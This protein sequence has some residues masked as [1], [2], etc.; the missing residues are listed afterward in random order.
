MN[1]EQIESNVKSYCRQYPC[2]FNTASGAVL[3]DENDRNYI[4]F[5]SGAGTL[6][7]GH[8]NAYLK[9]SLIEYI[10]NDGITHGLDFSTTAKNRFMG[11]MIEH[12]LKPRGMDYKIQFPGPTGTNAVEVALKI[13]R[14]ATKRHNV[15]A[16]TRSFHG[17]SMG[18]LATTSSSHYREASG[19]PL[20]GVSFMPFDGYLGDKMNTI[21]YLEQVLNDKSSGI[22]YP[23]AVLVETIQAEGG[24]NVASIEWLQALDLVCKKHQILLI[25]DDIQVGCGRTGAFFS[26]EQSG[27]SPDIILLSKS[28]S[29]YGLPLSI[30]LMKPQLDIWKPGQ[31]N[32]TFRGNNLAFVTAKATLE[33]YWQDSR[34][35]ES[36]VK[37]SQLIND[38]LNKIAAHYPSHDFTV[39]G[40]GM[41]Q[42]LDLKDGELSQA[43][44]ERAFE[45]GLIIEN[46]G[47]A[48]SV[49]KC[50][51]P[52]TISID[53]LEQGLQRLEASVADV[54][55][56][57]V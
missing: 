47:E 34:F 39:R 17:V 28:L 14:N 5:F 45:S 41:I 10:Q 6:N 55:C 38:G 33:Q 46:C 43:V 54:M 8:N 11:A 12:I 27:I 42:A 18:A 16:F 15:I 52:L 26:F 23:A 31:H 19:M 24:V 9:T 57:L 7:Y 2:V 35:I 22:D 32:G 49:L 37:K 48:G 3:T 25:V 13:A 30:V 4:D 56:K 20:S 29:G 40:R 21:D 53:E 50:I 1:V 36:V 44:L 51:P